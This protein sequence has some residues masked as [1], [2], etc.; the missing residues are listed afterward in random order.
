MMYF[1]L[2]LFF[3][4]LF[5]IIIMIERKLF[6]LQNGQIIGITETPFEVSYLE[7]VKLSVIAN[8][9][10]YEHVFLVGTLRLYIRLSNY[11]KNKYQEVK[12]KLRNLAMKED[13]SG[14]KKEISKF[15]KVIVEYKN[16]I[17]DIKHKIKR[18]ED[19]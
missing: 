12:I 9:K 19:L 11:F 13:E 10:K 5:S 4:S 1:L 18:E 3:V 16:R 2:I 15:L 8:I 14:E 6:L 7:K 17:R